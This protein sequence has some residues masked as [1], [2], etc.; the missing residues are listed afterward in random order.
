MLLV[1][2]DQ[3]ETAEWSE[4]GRPRADDDAALSPADA[5]PLIVAFSVR[6][7]A[8][9]DRNA[10]A[11]RLSEE[12]RNSRSQG[13]LGDEHQHR[14]ARSA[15]GVSEAEV[16]LRLAAARD[17]MEQ[18]DAERAAVGQRAQS[19][20]TPR[21]L[22]SQWPHGVRSGGFERP[23]FEWIAIDALMANADQPLLREPRDGVGAHSTGRQNP[24]RQA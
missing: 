17:P 5:L 2:D 15:D 1:H 20:E 6:Q 22:R 18:R 9:L 8:V 3:A 21:L 11:E 4:D 23:C 16:H 19:S 7:R 24:R 14:A 10:V 12:R 13:Y